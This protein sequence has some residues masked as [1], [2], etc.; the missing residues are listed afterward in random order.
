M[1]NPA[2][3]VVVDTHPVDPAGVRGLAVVVDALPD[4]PV[5][6]VT[7]VRMGA[8]VVMRQPFAAVDLVGGAPVMTVDT[9][10]VMVEPLPPVE[11]V[12]PVMPVDPFVVVRHTLAA[13][14]VTGDVMMTGR[15][16]VEG[17]DL[18]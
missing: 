3:P 1:V 7:V 18:L 9:L 2:H 8:L 13:L 4:V 12:E 6:A 17:G 5:Q 11:V 10:V 15:V 16:V 14:L